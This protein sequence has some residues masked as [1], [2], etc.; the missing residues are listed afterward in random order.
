LLGGAVA[1]L[2]VLAVALSWR[3]RR[4]HEV[5]GRPRHGPD[6]EAM[7]QVEAHDVDDMLDGIAE[8]RRRRGGRD[9]GEELA[10]ELIRGTWE[11]RG[12]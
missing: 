1:A 3:S 5:V 6:Y 7:A 4:E 2:V 8:R 11:E 12:G 9:L 10:D